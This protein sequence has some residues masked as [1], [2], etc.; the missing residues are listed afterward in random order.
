M[1]RWF[2][3]LPIL[4]DKVPGKIVLSFL[5]LLLSVIMM[6]IFRTKDR[7]L[8]TIAMLFSFL[9]DMA[10]N[11]R[12]E[13]KSNKSFL[14]GGICFSVS[15]ILYFLAY[16][17]LIKRGHYSYFNNGVVFS[18]ITLLM[19]TVMMVSVSNKKS[20]KLAIA[21]A[22]L[23]ISG[24]NY[25]TISSYS[26]SAQ[27]IASIA[28]IGGLFFLLSDVIIGLEQL[29]NIKSKTLRELVW[30]FYPIGQIII[31]IFA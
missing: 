4:G 2:D 19:I 15:H 8:C 14:I 22:Y 17:Q 12:D 30:W 11:F 16:C 24:I 29:A 13:K 3:H 7:A 28:C 6:A 23:W 5:I 26:F 18:V 1:N 9:G 20:K 10:L 25:I 21:I 27:S 31:I